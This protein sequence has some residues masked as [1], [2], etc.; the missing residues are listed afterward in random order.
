FQ[1]LE[2]KKEA[3]GYTHAFLILKIP[4]RHPSG[5]DLMN[6]PTRSMITDSY[7]HD[8][9]PNGTWYNGSAYSGENDHLFRMMPIT[10]TG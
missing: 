2:G 8:S 7:C 6:L 10:Q 3:S 5:M 9:P 1:N 4:A